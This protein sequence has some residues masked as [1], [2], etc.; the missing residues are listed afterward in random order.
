MSM[1]C[2]TPKRM[3]SRSLSESG[4]ARW[5]GPR[6][7]EMRRGEVLL[8]LLT[9]NPRTGD[10][11]SGRYADGPE[12]WPEGKVAAVLEFH[13]ESSGGSEGTAELLG[14][15]SLS[16]QGGAVSGSWAFSPLSSNDRDILWWTGA[17]CSVRE[18]LDPVLQST[19]R[20]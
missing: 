17:L 15:C 5:R 11:S 7:E 2:S 18:M 4:V 16:L 3:S 19:S 1:S 9:V 6:R 8:Y 12:N 13:A 10:L 20:L 14:M